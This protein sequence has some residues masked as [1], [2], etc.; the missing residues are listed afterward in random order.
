MRANR[1]EKKEREL[2]TG[3][4]VYSHV[5]VDFQHHVLVLV[6]EEDAEGG[7][8]LWN[9]AWLG[10]AWDDAHSPHYTLDGCMV[11]GLQSLKHRDKKQ[12][13]YGPYHWVHKSVFTLDMNTFVLHN[14]THIQVPPW[15]NALVVKCLFLLTK[16]NSLL[17]KLQLKAKIT[18]KS[19]T[20]LKT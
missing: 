11:R 15:F 1:R 6:K 12:S 2:S 19:I 14:A 4:G 13:L 3:A 20:G 8:L 9:A 7:H 18:R 5:G 17:G 16:Q 10:D